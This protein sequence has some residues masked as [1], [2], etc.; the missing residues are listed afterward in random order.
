MWWLFISSTAIWVTSSDTS[1]VASR[2]GTK[3][4]SSKCDWTRIWAILNVDETTLNLWVWKAKF[5]TP[6]E[7][8]YQLLPISNFQNWARSEKVWG[9]VSS[10][11]N[12]LMHISSI[13]IC[14]Y[15]PSSHLKYTHVET[16]SRGFHSFITISIEFA[17]LFS[18]NSHTLFL[19]LSWYL[20]AWP[21]WCRFEDKS[22]LGVDFCSKISHYYFL[23]DFH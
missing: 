3:L 2:A 18:G 17:N 5:T 23:F 10:N 19:K 9:P 1:S 22:Q 7:L 15:L 20:L 12:P 8:S 4:T 21:Q 11:W 6:C 16:R 13:F 14:N